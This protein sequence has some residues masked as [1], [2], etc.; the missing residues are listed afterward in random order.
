MDV[1]TI[2]LGELTAFVFETPTNIVADNRM[3]N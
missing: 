1:N 3:L 2:A